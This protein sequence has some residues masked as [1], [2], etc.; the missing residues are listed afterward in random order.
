MFWNDR[1]AVL[2]VRDD[3]ISVDGGDVVITGTLVCLQIVTLRDAED[4]DF[5]CNIPVYRV[6]CSFTDV[7]PLRQNE[8]VKT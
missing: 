5:V 1:Q 8:Q 3:R 7:T 2:S 6:L 4:E